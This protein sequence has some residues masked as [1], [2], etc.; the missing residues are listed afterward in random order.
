VGS[1][2]DAYRCDNWLA[3]AEILS[4]KPFGNKNMNP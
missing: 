1:A 3:A 4:G 2:A